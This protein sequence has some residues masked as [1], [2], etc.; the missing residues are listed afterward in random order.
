[1]SRVF[2]DSMLF[3][4]L[5]ENHP[6]YFNRSRYLLERSLE[7]GDEL[8]TS[9]LVLGEVLAGATKS[10]DP[11]KTSRI[12]EIADEMGF[13]ALPFDER[14]VLTFGE[15]RSSRRLKIA[16]SI[17]LACASAARMDLFLTGDTQL[18]GLHVPGIHFVSDFETNIL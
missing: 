16:D 10:P 6:K 15:L 12:R 13:K 11:T 3:I 5:L 9:C 4:Y 18:A 2:W 17:N 7:R 1:M 14:A 8:F